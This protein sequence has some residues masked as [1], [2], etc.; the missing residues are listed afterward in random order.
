MTTGKRAIMI[1]HRIQIILVRR[2]LH[3]R[4]VGAER[5]R[6]AGRTSCPGRQWGRHVVCEVEPALRKV[7]NSLEFVRE[8]PLH[9]EA[10]QVNQQ[11]GREARQRE[12]C[13]GFARAFAVRTVPAQECDVTL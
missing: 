10:L 13:G 9:G 4:V 11:H 1:R 5:L 7:N 12:L 2:H 8:R 3:A 6:G